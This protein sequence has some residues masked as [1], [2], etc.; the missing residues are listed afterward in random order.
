MKQNYNQ[1]N[2]KTLYQ[3]NNIVNFLS[4]FASEAFLFQLV[5]LEN[6]ISL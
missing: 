3:C 4:T 2:N 5:N 6:L 1:I